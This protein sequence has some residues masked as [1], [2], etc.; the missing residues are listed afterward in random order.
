MANKRQKLDN[1]FKSKVAIEALRGH[2]TLAQIASDYKVHP[3]QV[4]TWK[5]QLETNASSLFERGVSN[6]ANTEESLTAP[7][8]EEIGRLKMDIRW[9]EKKL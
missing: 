5:K 9:L 8:F 7:L 6:K 4:S 3:N 1:K 2:K